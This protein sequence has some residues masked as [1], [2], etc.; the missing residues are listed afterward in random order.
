MKQRSYIQFDATPTNDGRIRL[1]KREVI[2]HID[3]KGR[4]RDRVDGTWFDLAFVTPRQAADLVSE[5][6]SCLAYL[7]I[8][9][10]KEEGE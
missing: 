1:S 3:A 6:T 8:E 2:E 9:D 4:K 7:V 10:Y 5:I